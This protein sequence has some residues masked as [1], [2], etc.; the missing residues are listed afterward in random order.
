MGLSR[1]VNETSVRPVHKGLSW[2]HRIARGG[3]VVG[4]EM[5]DKVATYIQS[6]VESEWISTEASKFYERAV[7]WLLSELPE[8]AEEML[9]EIDERLRAC[10]CDYPNC[11]SM[12]QAYMERTKEEKG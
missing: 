5:S 10:R 12:V 3:D 1:R 9:K 11:D 6:L 8:G 7:R 2:V 4:S